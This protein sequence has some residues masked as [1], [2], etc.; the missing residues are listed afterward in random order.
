M[1][2]AA[3]LIP[4]PETI[5]TKIRI[6]RREAR[7]LRSLLRLAE[8]T[9]DCGQVVPPTNRPVRAGGGLAHA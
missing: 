8:Q 2:Q 3:R 7:V 4:K 5:R 1:T 6:L 9:H